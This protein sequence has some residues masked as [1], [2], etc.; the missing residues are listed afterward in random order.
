MSLHG[1]AK[2][3]LTDPKTGLVLFKEEHENAI[4]PT[5]ARI[6]GSN[7][8]G[9]L[10]YNKIMP[11]LSKLLGGVC[12]FNGTV[13][14]SDVFLPTAQ[15][16]QLTAHAGQNTTFDA[17]TDAKRGF[18]N[19]ALCGPIANG[20]RW[21]WQWTSTGNGPISDIVLTHADTGDFW[22]E[23]SPN[24]MDSDFS[25][26]G[27][28]NNGV[29]NPS[30]FEITG[31]GGYTHIV[32]QKKIPLGFI[33]DENRVVTVEVAD[34]KLIVH[35][36]KFTGSGAWIWNNLCDIED[37]QTFEWTPAPFVW[38]TFEALGVCCFYIAYDAVNKKVYTFN[39]GSLDGES[40]RNRSQVLTVNT[41]DLETGATDTTTINCAD[42]LNGYS[43]YANKS[44]DWTGIDAGAVFYIQGVNNTESGL[45]MQTQIIN[46]S[47]ILPV[48][49]FRSGLDARG[50]NTDCS[51]RVN[52]TNTNDQEIIKGFYDV[53][54]NYRDADH[55]RIDLG[56]GRFMNTICM[57]WKD[58]SG[59]YKGQEISADPAIVYNDM[60]ENRGYC[61]AG[62][63]DNPVQFMSWVNRT[64][65]PDS[66]RGCILNKL[67]AATVFHIENGPVVKTANLNMTLE[68]EITQEENES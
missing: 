53:S 32:N 44:P 58:S 39:A 23:N 1:K 12:L 41:L 62:P 56:N 31:A 46:G 51:I 35:V 17:A 42:T 43:Q 66:I 63:G 49:W 59:N 9:C 25:P 21:T 33:D 52:L 34:G 26:V 67:Y 2:L 55:M 8:G 20:Y 64:Q 30:E 16:A 28:I 6:F 60:S 65:Q 14:A 18:I 3:L 19:T 7:L 24:V 50:G 4:T 40:Y 10:N 29:V 68:Y 22:N 5:L 38:G 45:L 13:N 15:E 61:A 47:V 57:A 37:E 36:G 54:Y 11:V 27:D 48:L